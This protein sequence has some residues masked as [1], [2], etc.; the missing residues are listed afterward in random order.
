M[1]KVDA[2]SLEKNLTR[3]SS[4]IELDWGKARKG[5][6]GSSP[7]TVGNLKLAI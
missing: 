3:L 1:L 2:G 4:W 6:I 5:W 7:V